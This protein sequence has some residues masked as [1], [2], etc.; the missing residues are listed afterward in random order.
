[1]E[2]IIEIDETIRFKVSFSVANREEGFDDDSR[3]TITE[4]G[5][6]GARSFEADETSILL[7]PV[8]AEQL[9]ALSEKARRSRA[10]PWV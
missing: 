7:T 9:A 1:M 8:Q 10:T 3:F 6:Q 2:R 5:P 4:T